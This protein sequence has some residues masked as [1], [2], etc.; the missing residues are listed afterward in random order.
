[1]AT[2]LRAARLRAVRR[3]RHR[4]A[5]LAR[6]R[7]QHGKVQHDDDPGG[8]GR[9]RRRRRRGGRE[10]TRSARRTGRHAARGRTRA[11]AR[12]RSSRGATHW[13]PWML[14]HVKPVSWMTL[15]AATSPE[16][17]RCAQK[18]EGPSAR[19]VAARAAGAPAHARAP[20]RPR[21]SFRFCDSMPVQWLMPSE[22][23]SLRAG[24][25]G[26][27]GTARR[28]RR[29][30]RRSGG[31]AHRKR[32]ACACALIFF[33]SRICGGETGA[34]RGRRG[35]RAAAVALARNGR[36]GAARGAAGGA[37]RRA[38][39]HLQRRRRHAFAGEDAVQRVRREVGHLRGC[40]PA[41][42]EVGVQR[43][44][45]GRGVEDRAAMYLN[46]K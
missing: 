34:A 41:Q 24:G 14:L 42:R 29:P 46:G 23:S 37:S 1:M 15:K 22:S 33:S 11:H 7:A 36:G 30:A 9:R 20:A 39:A 18:R 31:A 3:Q 27:G 21:T 32:S 5:D 26:R 10:C 16:F 45:R 40:G 12:A 8:A 4:V 17:T 13:R 2:H 19:G 6:R 28:R 35:W 25:V 43:T 44:A 38:R